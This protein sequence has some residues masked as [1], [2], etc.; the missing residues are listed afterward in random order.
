MTLPTINIKGKEYTMVK[1][2]VIFFNETYGNGC[3][4][5]KIVSAPE[6]ARVVVEATVIPDVDKPARAFRDYSQAVIGDGLINKQAALENA[7]TSAVGRALA[8]MGIGVID[9]VASADEIK[10]ATPPVQ[11]LRQG[12]KN[13]LPA[14]KTTTVPNNATPVK[15]KA[16]DFPFG[17]NKE[18]TND[19]LPKEMYED[20]KPVQVSTLTPDARATAIEMEN[21]VPLTE[22]RNTEIQN[23]LKEL[24][25]TKVVGRRDL[26]LFLEAQHDGKKQFDVAA[27][28]WEAT[29]AKIE[30]AVADGSIKTLLKA[31]KG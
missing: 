3:I 19:D 23:R 28:Q 13:P 7:S 24:V 30:A 6:D 26:S 1:D 25:A 18:I 27:T 10:K 14:T 9:T 31:K 16:T 20:N 12:V 2:R 21:F 8:L 17:A 29:L 4:S 15:V 11:E 22:T 5:T